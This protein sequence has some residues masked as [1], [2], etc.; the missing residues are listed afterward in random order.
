MRTGG[1]TAD[2]STTLGHLGRCT[3]TIPYPW[4]HGESHA[5][6]LVTSTG[7]TFDHT[8]ARR[9]RDAAA[10][11]FDARH[12]RAHRLL[13]RRVARGDRVALV[14]AASRRLGRT[15]FDFVLALTIGLLLFLLVDTTG[16]TLEAASRVP[17]PYQGLIVAVAAA[18]GAFLA[19]AA[20]GAMAAERRV[21]AEEGWMLALLV[22]VGIG[23]HNFGEGLAIGAAFA[24]GEAA[25]GSLL[26]VGFTLHNTTEGLAIVS[27]LARDHGA[28]ARPPVRG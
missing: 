26:I 19:I 16:E 28:R 11:D 18:A 2:R 13:R 21:S 7:A 12:V 5:L 24:L 20:F 10:L 14:P 27:P 25:L 17:G 3:L 8:I 9:C 15:G 23:L 4:V 1:S 22:A 6:R